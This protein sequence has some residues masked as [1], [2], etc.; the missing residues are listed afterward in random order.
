MRK[1]KQLIWPLMMGLLSVL[2]VHTGF[3][4]KVNLPKKSMHL[5]A[6]FKVI[7]AQTGY[8]FLYNSDMLEGMPDVSVEAK[9][10]P[11]EKLLQQSLKDL[12]LTYT[13][14]DDKTIVIRKKKPI[15]PVED[16]PRPIEKLELTGKVVDEDGLPIGGASVVILG[17]KDGTISGSDGQFRLLVDPRPKPGRDSI[18]VSYVGHNDRH[19][20]IDASAP[21]HVV[22]PAIEH[23]TEAVMVST[24]YQQINRDNFTGTAVVVNGDELKKV[25]PQSILS[26]LQVFDPSFKIAEN[27]LLGSNPNALPQINVRGATAMPSGASGSIISRDNLSGTVNMPTF[28]LDGFEVDVQKIFDLDINRV[29]SI[30]LLK[31][32]A[33]TAVYGSRAANGVVVITTVP[34]KAGKLNLSYDLNLN[35]QTPDLS[36]YH[37]L[38]STEK[39]EYE[40]LAG[41]YS[42]ENNPSLSQD[43][44]DD[45]YYHKKE[46]VLSGINTDWLSQPVRSA[47]GQKHTL[48]LEGGTS[49]LRYGLSLRYQTEPGVMKG[50]SRDR[51]STEINLAYN[52][53]SKLLFKNT[54]SITKMN[55]VES[56]YGSFA[57]FVSMNPYYPLKDSLGHVSQVADIW[58][59]RESSGT[60]YQQYTLNPM[61]N[62]TLGGFNKNEYLE[63]IDAFSADWMITKGLRL[64]G[65]MSVNQTRSTA[66]RFISPFANEYYFYGADQA[67]KRG[68]YDYGNTVA[69]TLDGSLTLNYNRQLGLHN[70]NLVAGS[71]GQTAKTEQKSFVATGFSNDKFSDLGFASGYLEGSTPYSDVDERRL[72]GF[73]ATFNYSYNDK[74]LMDFTFR[75]DGSSQFGSNRRMAPFNSLGLGW[76]MHKEDFMQ[77]TPFSRFKLRASTGLTGSV[78]FS[79]YQSQTTY[80]YYLNNWYSTGPGGVVN[81][82]GNDNLEWQKTRAYD[83]GMEI[84][85]LDDR[86]L[87]LPKY[88][89][90]KTKGLISSV[91]LPPSTGFDAYLDNIGDMENKG[92]EMGLQYN[93]VKNKDFSLNLTAN[94]VHNENIIVKISDALKAYNDDVNDAQGQ[95]E[96]QGVPLLHYNEGQ[97]LN[98]IYAVPSLGIDPESGREVY[99][100]QDGT[101]TYE[102]DADDIR[103]VGIEEPKVYGYFG[104]SIRYKDFNLNFN[105]YTRLGGDHYN[106][107]LVDRVE[108]ADP[109]NN[110]DSRVFADKWR[111]PGD[112]AFYKNIADLGQTQT[113]SRFV[114]KDNV[115]EL[116]SVYLSYDLPQRILLNTAIKSLRLA[117]TM[118]SLVRWSSITE[119]R[120]IDYPFARSFNISLTG[121]F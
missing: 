113:V 80:D 43:Q 45:L 53:G 118:N 108:N 18:G 30:S 8:E 71:N 92:W 33:A 76:N 39:L 32:A 105:F 12:P 56:P 1:K 68:R 67:Q 109:R 100:K 57:N 81:N 70:I 95:S 63:V 69:T 27:N 13:I 110:V 103:P 40:R 10:L 116:N 31:D 38:N 77:N 37:V 115:L 49:Q 44:I 29:Q 19:F 97:S 4:Q 64:R 11:I 34:P 55:G 111:Q 61:Y 54:L 73:F 101:R 20:K 65:L 94:L 3:G 51:Y 75:E 48:F 7:R 60:P 6:L 106:Q 120:G 84:G 90:K 86:L 15:A 50:S 88:Y 74:Y 85:F 83:F 58:A 121:R 93:V 104:S 87:L 47:V 36:Q 99:L 21:L 107:T 26:S 66:D 46:L 72:I 28:I 5:E 96:N 89:I 91:T 24:G 42:K 9:D 117:F 22:L 35:V 2:F 112:H 102:W 23:E 82:Y 52:L 62:A 41:L 114:Q 119:E 25:N 17:T 16:Q 59:R 14:L 79:P 98:T 78:S